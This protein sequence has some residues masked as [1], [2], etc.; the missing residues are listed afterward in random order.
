MGE[1]VGQEPRIQRTADSI[2]QVWRRPRF[3]A[4]RIVSIENPAS[5]LLTF[6]AYNHSAHPFEFL[7][8]SHA[9]FDSGI[10]KRV[11]LPDQKQIAAFDLNGTANKSFVANSGPVSLVYAAFQLILTTDQPWWGIW[12]NRGGWPADAISPFACLG[13]EAT[14]SPQEQPAGIW[15]TPGQCF[16]GQVRAEIIEGFSAGLEGQ[17]CD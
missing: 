5:L 13:L 2:E 6:E 16:R 4:R 9:L 3:K 8:A 10:L 11:L 1:L 7:W 12:L 17:S 15:L 14:N